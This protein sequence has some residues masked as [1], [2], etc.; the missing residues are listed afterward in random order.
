VSL[1]IKNVGLGC[2]CKSCKVD[3]EEFSLDGALNLGLE[4]TEQATKFYKTLSK[5][6]KEVEDRKLYKSL[7]KEKIEQK[8]YLKKEKKF[9]RSTRNTCNAIDDFCV[10]HIT[11]RLGSK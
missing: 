9:Y 8:T 4:I 5:L 11:S 3:P 1:G 10:P 6:S 2:E 7:I